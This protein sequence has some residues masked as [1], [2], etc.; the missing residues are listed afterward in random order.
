MAVIAEDE[1]VARATGNEVVPLV[2]IEGIGVRAAIELV[3]SAPAVDEID[4]RAAVDPV[5]AGARLDPVV[6]TVTVDGVAAEEID[7]APYL[8]LIGRVLDDL[9]VA[10]ATVNDIAAEAGQD[11]VVSGLAVD[12]VLLQAP[13]A[14]CDAAHARERS[15][16]RCRAAGAAMT[17]K[18]GGDGFG[19][20]RRGIHWLV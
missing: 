13:S 5:V 6:A 15:G 12:V 3:G 10:V 2:T 4:A 8:G 1:V 18:A 14:A 17:G 11:R 20:G 19:D 7:I 9:V 16:L